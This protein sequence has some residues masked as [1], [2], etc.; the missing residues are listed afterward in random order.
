MVYSLFA[1]R[2]VRLT[3]SRTI[4]EALCKVEKVEAIM[5]GEGTNMMTPLPHY[6]VQTLQEDE[7]EPSILV[8]AAQRTVLGL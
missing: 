5:A 4:E 3:P 1:L 7:V 8:Q 2:Q 6:Q